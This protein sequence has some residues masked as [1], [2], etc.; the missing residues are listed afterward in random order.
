MSLPEVLVTNRAGE[1]LLPPLLHLGL[2]RKLFL[3][4]GAHVENQVG[5]HAEGQVAFGA[6]VLHR[7]S[8]GGEGRREDGE[9]GRALQRGARGPVPVLR[10][11]MERVADHSW[12]VGSLEVT[13]HYV[14]CHQ[15]G[16]SQ[17][18]PGGEGVWQIL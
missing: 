18:A 7:H 9:R 5:G 17:K 11:V 4:M 6:P 1:F 16:I 13:A 10:C 14:G 12:R 8:E 2:R 15:I 3:V